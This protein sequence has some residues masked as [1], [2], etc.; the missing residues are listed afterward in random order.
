MSERGVYLSQCLG[1]HRNRSERGAL[2]GRER[3]AKGSRLRGE[4]REEEEA[5]QDGANRGGQVEKK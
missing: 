1:A 3:A 5:N 2:L 4:N